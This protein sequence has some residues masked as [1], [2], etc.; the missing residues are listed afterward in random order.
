[1]GAH[2]IRSIAALTVVRLAGLLPAGPAVAQSATDSDPVDAFLVQYT[3]VMAVILA[4][5][6]IPSIVAFARKHPNRWLILVINIVFGG[7]GIGWLGSL[8]WA[9]NAVH[10]SRTG[11]DGGESGLNIFAND[12]VTVRVEGASF[13]TAT[14]ADIADRLLRLKSLREEDVINDDEY[15]RL[16][17]PLLDRLV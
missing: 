11:S 1:M 9:M 15:A 12:P 10:K 17:K 4:L 16:R 14:D 6:V 2:H 13:T 5:Y 3:V 8:V 7:T